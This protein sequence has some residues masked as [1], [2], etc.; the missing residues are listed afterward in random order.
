[1]ARRLHRAFARRARWPPNSQARALSGPGG[2]VCP[3]RCAL[4]IRPASIRQRRTGRPRRADFRRFNDILTRVAEP[5]RDVGMGEQG[6]AVN[7]V[8]DSAGK[9]SRASAPAREAASGAPPKSS[10]TTPRRPSS[11]RT[12]SA[13]ARSGVIKAA[14]RPGVSNASRRT[15][16]SASAS[17]RSSSASIRATPASD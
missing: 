16:A 9:A 15:M 2:R 8:A 6:G 11:S 12:R 7:V 14:V 5:A 10:I 1:M 3:R 13:R 4:S 17:S